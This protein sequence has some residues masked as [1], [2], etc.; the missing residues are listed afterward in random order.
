MNPAQQIFRPIT[1]RVRAFT[2]PDEISAIGATPLGDYVPARTLSDD[3]LMQRMS[4]IND[5]DDKEARA[6]ARS[7]QREYQQR[8]MSQLKERL[9][10][11]ACGAFI[12]REIVFDTET[13]DIDRGQRVRFGVAQ[14]HG[15]TYQ[16]ITSVLN[17]GV[18][19][20]HSDLNALREV[21]VFYNPRG[22]EKNE[23]DY[24][25]SLALLRTVVRHGFETP[26]CACSGGQG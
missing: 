2:W 19:L 9:G 15:M 23:A 1:L 14:V 13:T 4:R 18:T 6:L 8:A 25:R 10:K 7:A 3:E 5:D 20:T 17:D 26:G 21:Y 11:E 22:L 16:E 12:G 24:K